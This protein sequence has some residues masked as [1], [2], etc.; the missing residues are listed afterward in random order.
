MPPAASPDRPGHADLHRGALP[1]LLAAT[2]WGLSG[3]VSTLAPT[4]APTNAI[5]AAAM[6]LGG[7]LM[8]ATAPGARRLLLRARGR[9]E[10]MLLILGIATVLGYQQFFYPAVRQIGVAEATVIALGSAP[11]FSGLLARTFGREALSARWLC[12]APVAVLGCVMLVLGHGADSGVGPGPHSQVLGVI[13]ALIPGLAYAVTSAVAAHLI[14]AGNAPRATMGAMFG[15]AALLSVPV[16]LV[17][18]VGW[19]GSGRGAGVTV[20]LGV[21]TNFVCYTLFGRALRHTPAAVATTLTLAEGGV[22]AMMGVL[23]RGERLA[24][25]GWLGLG[26]LACALL[27]LSLPARPTRRLRGARCAGLVDGA[28]LADPADRPDRPDRPECPDPVGTAR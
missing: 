3:L 20:F 14:A 16:L 8:L 15:G 28:D 12:C 22:G 26:V 13:L 5:A 23:V 1:I 18:G 4:D 25:V 6:V 19:I 27:A 17:S 7:G 2:L 24:L 11:V 21:V 9:R 10:R